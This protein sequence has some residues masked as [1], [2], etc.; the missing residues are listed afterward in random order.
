MIVFRILGIMILVLAGMLL[1]WFLILLLCGLFV[2]PKREYKE[3]SRFYRFLLH[4]STA[5]ALWLVR[6]K[7]RASGLEKLP[8]GKRILFVGNHRSNYD[9]IVTWHVLRKWQP[10]FVSKK[11]NFKIPAFG[12]IIR[13]CCFLPIE[14][15]N[16][17]SSLKTIE[18]AAELLRGGEVSIGIYPEGTRSKS[19]I[20]L[21]FHNGVF[22]IAQKA[23]AAI[24]VVA[25]DGTEEIHRRTPFRPTVVRLCVADVISAEE[26]HMLKTSEIGERVRTALEETLDH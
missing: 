6:V 25:I 16:P 11:S 4:S 1:L 26:V 17:R 18:F 21:P 20:L 7:I 22:K 19:G 2:D 3:N 13:K 9:P 14:R 12:R 24:A 10:A 8:A 23:N 15:G 5:L